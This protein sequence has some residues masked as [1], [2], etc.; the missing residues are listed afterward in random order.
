MIL[1]IVKYPD[2]RLREVSKPVGEVTVEIAKLISDMIETMYAARGVGLAAIQ[3][4]VPLRILVMD[5]DCKWVE[6]ESESDVY[7]RV[8]LNPRIFINPIIVKKE[9]VVSHEEGC[10]SV[11]GIHEIVSRAHTIEAK[12]LNMDGAEQSEVFGTTEEQRLLAVC[13]QHEMDHLDGKLFIDRL[14]PIKK[15]LMRKKLQKLAEK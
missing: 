12:W 6:V 14:S 2:P 11:P 3:V 10:L 8:N 15:D 5:I 9:K 4:G 1:D 7:H 13:L